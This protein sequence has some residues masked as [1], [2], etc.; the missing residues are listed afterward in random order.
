MIVVGDHDILPEPNQRIPIHVVPEAGDP[1]IEGALF[2]VQIA[3]GGP[4]LGGTIPGPSIQ[5]VQL[6]ENL[7]DPNNTGA[8]GPTIFDADNEGQFGVGGSPPGSLRPQV[9][10]INTVTSLGGSVTA[11]GLLGII[12]LDGS[13]FGLGETFDVLLKDTLNGPTVFNIAGSGQEILPVITNG[14][15]TIVPEPGTAAMLLA[16]M[17]GLLLWRR[18]RV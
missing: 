17:V 10:D 11:D 9:Y 14:T 13:G 18:R 6:V 8:F 4:E 2:V 12:T 1:D 16:G 15:V 7:S 3:D 5:Y